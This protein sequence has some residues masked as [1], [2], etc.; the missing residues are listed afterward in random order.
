MVLEP[1][2]MVTVRVASL[3]T[4]LASSI[5]PMAR[6]GTMVLPLMMVG[7]TSDEMVC[8]STM[9]DGAASAGWASSPACAPRVAQTAMASVTMNFL[10]DNFVM[11]TPFH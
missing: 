5:S 9:M 6:T 3:Q 4:T 11:F 1:L 7:A 10:M 2:V 8:P